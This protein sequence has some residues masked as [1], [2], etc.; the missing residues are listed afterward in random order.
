M[1]FPVPP[2]P[3]VRP[4]AIFFVRLSAGHMGSHRWVGSN[5]DFVGHGTHSSGYPPC[6]ANITR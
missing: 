3:A 2:V 4:R 5:R 6:G 1:I